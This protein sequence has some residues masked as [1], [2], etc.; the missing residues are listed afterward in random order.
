[1]VYEDLLD[2]DGTRQ[3]IAFAAVG[4][5]AVEVVETLFDIQ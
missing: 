3:A 2:A 5:K 1:M 4:H